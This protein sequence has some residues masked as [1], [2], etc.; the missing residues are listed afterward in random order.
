MTTSYTRKGIYPKEIPTTQTKP[1]TE[2]VENNKD[3]D[4]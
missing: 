4:V 2:A 1:F 3:L